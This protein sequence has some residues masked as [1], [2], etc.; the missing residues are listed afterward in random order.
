MQTGSEECLRQSVQTWAHRAQTCPHVRGYSEQRQMHWPAC[1]IRGYVLS[2]LIQ[3][4]HNL[5]KHHVHI[6]PTTVEDKQLRQWIVQCCHDNSTIPESCPSTN[7]HH[8]QSQHCA[9]QFE[10]TSRSKCQE[11]ATAWNTRIIASTTAHKCSTTAPPTF[12]RRQPF[13]S[14]QQ[15]SW[16]SFVDVDPKQS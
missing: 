11:L 5:V 16:R 4:L 9:A 12:G 15:W 6:K 3:I 2:C 1:S 8:F 13:G 14:Q 7:Q 10:P